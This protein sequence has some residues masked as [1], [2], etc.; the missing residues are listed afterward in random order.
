MLSIM[1][2]EGISTG[3]L[4]ESRIGASSLLDDLIDGGLGRN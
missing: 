2:K 4:N 1:Q 3:N